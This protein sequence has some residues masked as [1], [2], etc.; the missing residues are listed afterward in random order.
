[1]GLLF[2]E[3]WLSAAVWPLLI[4]PSSFSQSLSPFLT[5]FPSITCRDHIY[6]VDTDTANSEEIFFSK[7]S[8]TSASLRMRCSL[9]DW[10]C[11][12]TLTATVCT[13]V[14]VGVFVCLPAVLLTRSPIGP[15][16]FAM[17]TLL[18]RLFNQ[19]AS[20]RHPRSSV[21][22]RE[23]WWVRNGSWGDSGRRARGRKEK[24]GGAG[25]GEQKQRLDE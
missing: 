11:N 18:R 4:S 22:Q 3:F 23:V 10:Q 13:Y 17:V 24:G 14:H 7:V 19:S 12:L 21:G 6:T 2:V 8:E 15:G 25:N 20:L 5:R 1:M 9:R 16:A